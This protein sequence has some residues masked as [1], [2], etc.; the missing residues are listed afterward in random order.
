MKSIILA[1]NFIYTPRVFFFT[2]NKTHL[3]IG[4]GSE[5]E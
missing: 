5:A 4:I 3:N 2:L 1:S